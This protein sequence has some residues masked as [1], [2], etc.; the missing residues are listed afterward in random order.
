[1][2]S[3]TLSSTFNKN[4]VFILNRREIK[5]RFDPFY[6]VPELVELEKKVLS[7]KPKQLRE[8]VRSIASGATPK[9]D[10]EEKYYSDIKNGVP[11]LR[12]QNV[13][14]WGLDLSDVKY[15]NKETHNGLLKRSQ[16]FENDL[17]VTITGRIASAAVAPKGFEGN[18]N[19]H[20]VVIKT[21][22]KEVSEIL[23][24]Y[25][26]C[27]VGQKLAL[28]NTTGG[29]RPALD[30]PA[31]LSIPILHDKRVLEI[32]RRVVE[33][34]KQNEVTAEKLLAGI[35]DYL[36]KELGIALPAPPENTLKNRIF[37]TSFNKITGQR[38]DP[39][40]HRLNYEKFIN[41]LKNSSFKICKLK[42]I[43]LFLD[44]G[45]MP[46]Q[47]YAFTEDEGL[48]MIRVTNIMK[49]GYIN[50]DKVEYIKFNTPKLKDKIVQENDILM[51]QCSNTTGKCAMVTK[52]F[53]GYTYGSFSFA[54]RT[55]PKIVNQHFL[56]YLLNSKIV[57][58]QLNRSI[59]ITSVR[60]NT[61]KPEVENF[62]IP[63]PP[64]DKQKK[65]AEHISAIR[66]EAQQL[67]DKTKEELKKASNEIEKILLTQ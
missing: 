7:K 37:T 14:E 42:D 22:S 57:Q 39:T 23:A 64:L 1:M 11:F 66:K 18:I 62:L 15:I 17:L 30:Y 38:Y 5:K 36:L 28:R 49:D 67:K 52:E 48:P 54:I 16:V 20:S 40:Y 29:T 44:Y 13:T 47:D 31:L 24:A 51:V 10:E 21:E 8:Y 35:D 2:S 12:V 19:Q 56:F 63:V 58:E 33:Q 41:S 34:K 55:N 45:L 4:K 6:Y 43:I 32:T 50:M 9:R 60:P 26:N 25:L 27:S 46:T 65:I 61:T 53:I 59:T 3:F